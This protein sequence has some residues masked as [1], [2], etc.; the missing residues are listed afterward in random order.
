L[1]IA[2]LLADEIRRGDF[3]LAEPIA[4]L[5]KDTKMKPLVIRDKAS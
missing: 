3:Q 2:N 5:P 4:Y 1:E